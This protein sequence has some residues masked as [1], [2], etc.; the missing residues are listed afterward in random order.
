[1][2]NKT[3]IRVNKFALMGCS[4]S[5]RDVT[6]A[7]LWL[8]KNVVEPQKFAKELRVSYK[9]TAFR[10]WVVHEVEMDQSLNV[11]NGDTSS[12]DETLPP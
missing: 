6:T 4:Q 7:N 12:V 2:N 11:N 8:V 1:M 5:P 10:R 3:T 9:P